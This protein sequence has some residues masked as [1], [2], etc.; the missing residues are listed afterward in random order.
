MVSMRLASESLNCDATDTKANDEAA[1]LLRGDLRSAS[2]VLRPREERDDMS[3]ETRA[4]ERVSYV[5]A[6]ATCEFVQ[7]RGEGCNGSTDCLLL[8]EPLCESLL[9]LALAFAPTSVA[10]NKLPLPSRL[11]CSDTM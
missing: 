4:V 5:W 6:C 3:M 2:D 9:M 7:P 8:A 1:G 10:T 11:R